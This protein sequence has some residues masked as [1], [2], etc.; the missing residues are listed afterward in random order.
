MVRHPG[1]IPVKTRLAAAIG[2]EAAR[3]L[4]EALAA[5]ALPA[6]AAGDHALVVLYDPPEAG[7]ATARWLGTG[8]LYRPQ[9]GRDLGRRMA[10][11]FRVAFEEGYQ[12][13]VLVGSDIP[14]LNGSLIEA[15]FAGLQSGA[16]VLGPARDGGYYLIGFSRETFL[17]EA[18]RGIPWGSREVLAKTVEILER[19]RR[20]VFLLPS[21]RDVDTAED[22]EYIAAALPPEAGPA[23]REW[24]RH[25]KERGKG[26]P[27]RGGGILTGNEFDPLAIDRGTTGPVPATPASDRGRK[28]KTP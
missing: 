7:E 21:R 25:Y 5:D 16:A 23:V 22:L 28:G 13:A 18:F 14:G 10:S 3:S 2:P 4:Y 27:K 26:V 15:A 24:L 11:G 17:P 1:H 6:L 8:P 12:Q 20:R 9:R 19:H